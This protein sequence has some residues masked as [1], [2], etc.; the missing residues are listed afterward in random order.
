MSHDYWHC[1][2]CKGNFDHGEK[3]DCRKEEEDEVQD[4]KDA[5]QSERFRKVS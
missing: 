4:H 2:V 3:C 1:P 5:V